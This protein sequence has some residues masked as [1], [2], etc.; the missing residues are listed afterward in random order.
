MTWVFPAARAP[1]RPRTKSDGLFRSLASKLGQPTLTL[2][3][4]RVLGQ[5]IARAYRMS[6]AAVRGSSGSAASHSGAHLRRQV[7]Q[8]QRQLAEAWSRLLEPPERPG[9]IPTR[10]PSRCAPHVPEILA[11]RERAS[12]LGDRTRRRGAD[13]PP[14]CTRTGRSNSTVE[15][16]PPDENEILDRLAAAARG[17]RGDDARLRRSLAR[18]GARVGRV[19]MCERLEQLAWGRFD[20]ELADRGAS[21]DHLNHLRTL[22][23]RLTR[24]MNS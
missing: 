2:N 19:A 8:E 18:L 13:L 21:P 11:A 12:A 4:L 10:A 15:P 16:A 9:R 7:E 23:S 14:S 5:A 24:E 22:A 6:R 1:H 17:A 3:D 20:F